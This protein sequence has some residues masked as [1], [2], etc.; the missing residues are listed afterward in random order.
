MLGWVADDVSFPLAPWGV[1]EHDGRM[2]EHDRERVAGIVVGS[3]AHRGAGERGSLSPWFIL[4]V[5][6]SLMLTGLVADGSGKV[7]ALTRAQH[8]AASAA[9][10]ATAGLE[11]ESLARGAPVVAAADAARIASQY[12][13]DHGREGFVEL[14]GQTMLVSVTEVYQTRFLGL[15]GVSEI[16]VTGTASALLIDGPL[17]GGGRGGS[18]AGEAGAGTA[19]SG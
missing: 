9:R 14:R 13:A 17:P 10:A 12:I 2:R 8:I 7:Q 19:G 5:L 3:R 16:S 15:I 11:G 18:A 6:A 1:G 4:M